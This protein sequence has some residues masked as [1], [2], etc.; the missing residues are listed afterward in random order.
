MPSR[1][2]AGFARCG[3]KE[4]KKSRTNV[5]NSSHT[6]DRHKCNLDLCRPLRGHAKIVKFCS[7]E[8]L[9]KCKKK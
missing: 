4:C 8:H 9:M 5:K 2:Q 6:L 3:L 7:K 1:R